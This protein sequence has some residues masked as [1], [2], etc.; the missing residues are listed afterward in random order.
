[1]HLG[2]KRMRG[3]L[4]VSLAGIG[5]GGARPYRPPV[6]RARSTTSSN[7]FISRRWHR[8]LRHTTPQ[9]RKTPP[10]IRSRE[11]TLEK[12]TSGL[13]RWSSEDKASSPSSSTA[14]SPIP[15]FSNHICN[16]DYY[17]GF[18]FEFIQFLFIPSIWL[19]WCSWLHPC[20]SCSFSSW[21]DGETLA[22]IW[23]E[24]KMI[25]DFKY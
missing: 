10:Q 19:W 11:G 24:S 1:M 21:A 9:N 7:T 3:Q 4:P 6:Q 12:T 16:L 5:T 18:V 17:C 15:S 23:D 14:A 22:W 25:Y 13:L 8:D 2:E 20:V